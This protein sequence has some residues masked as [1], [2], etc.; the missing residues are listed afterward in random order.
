MAFCVEAFVPRP[1]NSL[2]RYHLVKI[3]ESSS[4]ST[5]KSSPSE[6]KKLEEELVRLQNIWQYTKAL[7]SR[8]RAQIDSEST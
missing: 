2:V 6:L 4:D 3:L 8:N 5:D 1:G 7:I